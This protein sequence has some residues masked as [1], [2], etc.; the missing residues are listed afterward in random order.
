MAALP[1]R[2]CS[3]T[4]TARKPR[5]Q[6]CPQTP[7][8]FSNDA[9][10]QAGLAGCAFIQGGVAVD[11]TVTQQGIDTYLSGLI[12]I[13]GALTVFRLNIT[14]L[15]L[16]LLETVSSITL[17]RLPSL[18]TVNATQLISCHNV[19]ISDTAELTLLTLPKVTALQVLDV[20]AASVH[21]HLNSVT[22]IGTATFGLHT[23]H[24]PVLHTVCLLI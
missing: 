18:Q 8:L 17:A 21:V 1:V 10:L 5:A 9:D 16:P 3:S 14:L 4:A 24:A 2:T 7:V 6:P 20:K 12:T 23:F 15:D 11:G 19:K 22:A 13:Q